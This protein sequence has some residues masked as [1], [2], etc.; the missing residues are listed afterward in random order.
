L[1]AKIEIICQL[2]NLLIL[3]TGQTYQIYS[4]VRACYLC[5]SRYINCWDCPKSLKI[6]LASLH[7][8]KVSVFEKVDYLDNQFPLVIL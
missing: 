4:L 3:D 6:A 1:G 2:A 8:A 7:F 5:L